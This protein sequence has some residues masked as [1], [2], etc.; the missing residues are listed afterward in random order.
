MIPTVKTHGYRWGFRNVE[1]KVKEEGKAYLDLRVSKE[2]RDRYR[3][4]EKLRRKLKSPA[5]SPE[6]RQQL[7]KELK[8]LKKRI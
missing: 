5:I 4:M 8:S 1:P 2:D 7:E 6:T 3:K